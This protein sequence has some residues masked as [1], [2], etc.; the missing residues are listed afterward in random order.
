[1]YWF[2]GPLIYAAVFVVAPLIQASNTSTEEFN[3]AAIV[4]AV[5]L[6]L[7]FVELI[8]YKVAQR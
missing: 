3:T 8:A 4:I 1:M 6:I 5:F 2:F 7:A